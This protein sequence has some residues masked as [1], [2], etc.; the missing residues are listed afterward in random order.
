MILI[1]KNKKLEG[2]NKVELLKKI[3][4][5]SKEKI[6]LITISVMASI[7]LTAERYAKSIVR[8]ILR[9]SFCS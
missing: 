3:I 1:A 9:V 8:Y 7:R 4:V 5:L 6:N 2:E